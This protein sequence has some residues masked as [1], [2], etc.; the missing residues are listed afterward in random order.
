MRDCDDLTEGDLFVPGMLTGAFIMFVA[1]V[2]FIKS[3]FTA[4][5]YI[6]RSL[7]IKVSGKT[8]ICR[9]QVVTYQD[10]IND[11]LKSTTK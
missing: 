4:D 10:L 8:F 11:P 3:T 1:M 9:E 2:F 7:P 5:G 6:E